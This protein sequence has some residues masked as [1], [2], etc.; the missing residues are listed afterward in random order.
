MGKIKNLSIKRTI[1]LYIA[2]SLVFNFFLSALIIRWATRY[3]ENIWRGYIEQMD[4]GQGAEGMSGI[5]SS[6]EVE[7][8]SNMDMSERDGWLSELCDFLQTWTVL[9]LSMM[10]CILAIFLFYRH[11][12]KI[13]L[14]EL[15]NGSR[16]ISKNNLEFNIVYESKDELGILCMEFERMRGQ[17]YENNKKLWSMVEQEK[18]LRSA[19]AHD[20]RSPLA[21]LKGYQEMLLEFIPEEQLNQDKVVEILEAGM[22]QINRLDGFV[23]TMRRLSR[24]DERKLQYQDI[25]LSVLADQLE[26][27]AVM[28]CK[29]TDKVLSFSRRLPEQ[30][31]Q[32]DSI[33]VAEVF[34]NL[35]S[36][37]LRYAKKEVRIEVSSRDGYFQIQMKDDG[38]GF[39]VDEETATKVYYHDN[40]TDDLNHFGLGLYLCRI[41]CEKHGGKLLLG[42]QVY[43]GAYVKARFK[44]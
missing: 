20:I 5:E 34:E 29:M 42:N 41:Y 33:V 2:I 15:T 3:Q 21:V 10:G 11:K 7:R 28:M 38:A 6:Q 43:G 44:I 1:V 27:T 26:Q 13:P 37:A 9:I 12:I 25:S 14:E 24:L 35:L 36:N 40:S 8:V 39:G 18:A 32:L 17:L 19:I 30:I 22:G 4:A 31:A 23:D 16:K